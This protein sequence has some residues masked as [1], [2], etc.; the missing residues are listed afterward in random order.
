MSVLFADDT[1]QFL[2]V[3]LEQVRNVDFMLLLSTERSVQ[4]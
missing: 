1:P 2:L 4:C 3:L